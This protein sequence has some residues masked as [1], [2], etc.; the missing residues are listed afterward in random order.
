MA[1]V[2]ADGLLICADCLQAIA[3]DDYTGLDYHY[4]PEEADEREARIRA[5]IA[6]LGGYAVA[7]EEYG[8]SWQ[9][10]DCCG[11]DLGGDK[12]TCSVLGE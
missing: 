2:I 1:Q 9:G 12:W 3:N 7:G 8:F 11:S 6:G 10:C 5:G 4:S